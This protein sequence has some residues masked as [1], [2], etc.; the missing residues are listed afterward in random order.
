MLAVGCADGIRR[1]PGPDGL[2]RVRCLTFRDTSW[3]YG[4]SPWHKRDETGMKPPD[5]RHKSSAVLT[6]REGL[7]E[8]SPGSPPHRSLQAPPAQP[9]RAGP[10]E[11]PRARQ[12]TVSRAARLTAELLT[13]SGIPLPAAARH[14]ASN[15]EPPLNCSNT[16]RQPESPSPSPR[17]HRN[18]QKCPACKHPET[19][20]HPRPPT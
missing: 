6:A 14:P 2:R 16:P 17:N 11:P 10:L 7:P 18:R 20:T 9:P 12:A 3:T 5:L 8:P 1:H 13:S 19:A 15:C 4:A